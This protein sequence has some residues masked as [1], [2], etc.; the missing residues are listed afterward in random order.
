MAKKYN[1]QFKL[2]VIKD[3]YNSPLGIRAIAAK[4]GLPSKNYIGNWEAQLKKKGLLP[5]D[6]TK[7]NKTVGRTKEN[8]LREDKRTPREKQ[9]EKEIQLL[10]MKVA[11]YEKL[12]SL[13]P[14]L[15]KKLKIRELKYKAILE[16]E[17]SYPTYLLCEIAGVSKTA[18]YRYKKKPMKDP[19]EI[20]T[21]IIDV[22]N[23]SNKRAGYRSIKYILKNKYNR[24]VNHK[25]V[26]R[27]MRK[28]G[29]YSIV[30]K[31]SKKPHEQPKIK[32][33]LLSRDF[34]S[35]KP[36]KKFVTDITYIPTPHK[37]VY[38]CTVID[39][40]NREPVAWNISDTQD[41][42]LSINTI[43]QLATKFDLEDVIIHSDRGVHYT[44]KEYVALLEKLKVNQSMSRKGNCWDNALAESFFSHLKCETIYLMK[45]QIKDFNGVKRIIEEYMDYYTN[46]R[47]QK[48]LG[49]LSPKE[50]KQYRLTA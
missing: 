30:R 39:L 49:G 47:P 22:F 20:E 10:K 31:K 34:T 17:L 24:I 44:N 48:Y 46:D 16:L 8:I 12:D 26:Q 40:F 43:E 50:Y 32:N 2:S 5:P 14:F 11:Y 1:D 18:F 4:Y 41:K 33:N 23:K 25:K 3:Y 7:P 6:A 21:L 29:L 35:T 15:K 13:Q 37:M 27:I 45:T 42:Y 9:Y 28:N 36:G 19:D 38:L